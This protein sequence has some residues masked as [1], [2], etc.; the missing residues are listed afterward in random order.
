MS[1]TAAPAF[2]EREYDPKTVYLT[3]PWGPSGA[4]FHMGVVSEFRDGVA[5]V[6]SGEGAGTSRYQGPSRR[7]VYGWDKVARIEYVRPPPS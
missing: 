2:E 5:V 3:G 7:T 1:A 4:Y 6:P